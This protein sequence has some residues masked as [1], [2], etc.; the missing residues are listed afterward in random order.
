MNKRAFCAVLLMVLSLI[1][2]PETSG[3]TSDAL[4]VLYIGGRWT[5]WRFDPNTMTSEVIYSV[6]DESRVPVASLSPNEQGALA[7]LD[8]PQVPSTLSAQVGGLWKLSDGRLLLK[9]D[10]FACNYLINAEACAGYAELVILDTDKTTRSIFRLEYHDPLI[11]DQLSEANG[12]KIGY[13][14]VNPTYEQAVIDLY[15]ANCYYCYLIDSWG[16]LIDFSGPTVQLAEMPY[17]YNFNWSPDGE[18]LAYFDL[19]GC[20]GVEIIEE[21]QADLR[22]R[23]NSSIY[24]IATVPEVP[25]GPDD[26]YYSPNAYQYSLL[27]KDSNTLIFEQ[28]I[29]GGFHRAE[30]L[31]W[32]D[33]VTD[34]MTYHPLQELPRIHISTLGLGGNF[35]GTI[36]NSY[37][38]EPIQVILSGDPSLTVLKTLEGYRILT[39]VDDTYLIMEEDSKYTTTFAETGIFILMPDFQIVKVLLP[40]EILEDPNNW[41]Y[42]IAG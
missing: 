5:V 23:E 17:S 38:E 39:T 19:S 35:V 22:F 40:P 33:L 7:A 32:Y 3:Q 9:V 42:L 25:P 36:R 29:A 11:P 31:V 28:R 20:V 10:H 16:L 14:E 24:S 27:W 34:S 12:T 41:V 30:A 8:L 21:C 15:G 6:R 1:W 26:T 37:P 4:P 13:V 18:K 2:T